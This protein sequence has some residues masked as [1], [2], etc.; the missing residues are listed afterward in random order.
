TFVSDCASIMRRCLRPC[1]RRYDPPEPAGLGRREE[2]R[3]RAGRG[4]LLEEEMRIRSEGRLVPGSED[5]ASLRAASSRNGSSWPA[6]QIRRREDEIPCSRR[7]LAP[8]SRLPS[9]P[10]ARLSAGIVLGEG[11]R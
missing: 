5:G 11:S 3:D 2:T 6:P 1:Q 10:G 9:W 8:R 4:L 7:G